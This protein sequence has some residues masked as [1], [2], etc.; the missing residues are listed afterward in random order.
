MADGLVI[1]PMGEDFI[2][3]RCLH[4]GPLTKQ[5][6]EEWP[7]PD[8]MGWESRRAMNVPVLRQITKAYG[9]CAIL[10]R[11]GDKVVGSLRFY[12]KALCSVGG[13]L[14][15]QG[16]PSG[17]S[18][19]LAAK[20]LPSQE[21]MADKALRVHCMATGSPFQADNPYQRKGI[22]SQ[23]V[24]ELIRWAARHGWDAIEAGAFEDLPILY[25]HAGGAGKRFW[26]KL[27][28]RVVA[29][30]RKPRREILGHLPAVMREQAVA[31]GLDPDIAEMYT[32]R[33]GKGEPGWAI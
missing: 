3:W 7:T 15:L 21:Q 33:L 27:G 13:G 1:E 11:D 6:I 20:G 5:S 25:E 10:A 30:E 9:A 14:C 24:R 16:A 2:L 12:P 23:M 19:L 32:M 4:G 8:T 26:E 17:P 29:S 22:G 31:Q 18:D 28:F